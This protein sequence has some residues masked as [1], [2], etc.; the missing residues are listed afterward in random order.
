[1]FRMQLSARCSNTLGKVDNIKEKRRSPSTA[2][3]KSFADY[4]R[5]TA[6]R[7]F[8]FDRATVWFGLWRG[9]RFAC[10]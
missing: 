5:P 7:R 6:L 9:D 1:M 2:A 3:S 10:Q 4:L 8:V